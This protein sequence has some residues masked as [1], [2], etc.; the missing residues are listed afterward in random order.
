MLGIGTK[1][2]SSLYGIFCGMLAIEDDM[3][4]IRMLAMGV[5]FVG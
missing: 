2:V 3:A 5:C 4:Y 1:L